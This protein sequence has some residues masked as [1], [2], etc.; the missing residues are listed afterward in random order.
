MRAFTVDANSSTEHVLNQVINLV[1]KVG[2]ID[3][4]KVTGTADFQKDLSLDSLDKVELFMALEN[5][6]SIEIPDAE[7][8]KLKCCADVAKYVI[9][10]CTWNR[11]QV[12]RDINYEFSR[13][14]GTVFCP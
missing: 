6:F 5:E 13:T 10:T 9:S 8:D 4:T 2:R 3:S 7:A 14:I 12:G 11:M 1:K